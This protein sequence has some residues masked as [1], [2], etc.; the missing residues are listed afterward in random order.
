MRMTQELLRL[1]MQ[2]FQVI[3]SILIKTQ[4]EIFKS[5]LVYLHVS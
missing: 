1:R 4:W 2:N 5:A 3:I